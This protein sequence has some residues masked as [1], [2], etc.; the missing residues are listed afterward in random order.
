MK[1]KAAEMGMQLI[2]RTPSPSN[3]TKENQQVEEEFPGEAQDAEKD[4]RPRKE[5]ARVAEN[6]EG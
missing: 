3:T 5:N 6:A 1:R 2:R 4:K